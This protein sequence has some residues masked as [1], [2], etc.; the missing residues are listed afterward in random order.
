MFLATIVDSEKHKNSYIYYNKIN[1]K[2]I[3]TGYSVTENG[4]YNIDNNIIK[5]LLLFFKIGKKITKLEN[6]K[7]YSVYLDNETG[8]KHY[9]KNCKEDYFALLKFNG[10]NP[11]KYKTNSAQ[12]ENHEIEAGQSNKI[13]EFFNKHKRIIATIQL[14]ALLKYLSTVIDLTSDLCVEIGLQRGIISCDDSGKYI[15][16]GKINTY[17]EF[18][19]AIN[20]SPYLLQEDKEYL[21]NSE[22][23]NDI[24]PYYNSAMY[25][26]LNLKLNDITIKYYDHKE[27]GKEDLEIIGFYNIMEPNVLN[28]KKDAEKKNYLGHEFFHLLQFPN[29]R[30][31]YI[32]EATADI[33]AY[34]Y[35]NDLQFGYPEQTKNIRLLMDIIGPKIIWEYIF[36]GDERKLVNILKDNLDENDYKNII[37][38]LEDADCGRDDE[39]EQILGNLYK[40]MNNSNIKDNTDIY[41]FAGTYINGRYYFNKSKIENKNKYVIKCDKW[42]ELATGENSELFYICYFTP[43]NFN[44]FKE[45]NN[46]DSLFIKTAYCSLDP[47]VDYFDELENKLTLNAVFK[48]G[49][50]YEIDKSVALQGGVCEELIAVYIPANLDMDIGSYNPRNTR[51]CYIPKSLLNNGVNYEILGNKIIVEI[52]DILT[53]HPY[54]QIRKENFNLKRILVK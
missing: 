8:L 21:L 28:G 23:I 46:I 32:V 36:S 50:V 52:T 48:S 41:S 19:A 49:E 40:N 34:E 54:D 9:F 11:I 47:E 29:L 44:K 39:L 16:N 10:K 35:F 24:L 26:Y 5:D 17:E 37:E 14:A 31:D 38:I 27:S 43:E 3:F 51:K 42:N 2:F 22:L 30:F 13:L 33:G 12:E 18:A 7:G 45:N 1:N 6:Y 25:Y 15:K 53:M 20:N 4:I